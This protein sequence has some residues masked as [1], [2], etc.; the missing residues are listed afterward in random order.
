[1]DGTVG[2][3]FGLVTE[4]LVHEIVS[5]IQDAIN[6]VNDVIILVIICTN[7]AVFKYTNRVFKVH[8]TE[9]LHRKSGCQCKVNC[10]GIRLFNILI[11]Q[12]I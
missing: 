6:I 12:M 2:Y 10:D 3:R 1:M 4:Q 7:V 8:N 11:F 9:N 5:G